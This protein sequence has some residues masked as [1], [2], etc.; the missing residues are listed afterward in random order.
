MILKWAQHL[1]YMIKKW[2]RF[3]GRIIILF[4]LAS[5]LSVIVF[6]F[7]PIPITPLVV[8]RVVEQGIEKNRNIRFKKS[9]VPISKISQYMQLAVVCS[10]DQK[11]LKHFG[12]DIDAIKKASIHNKKNKRTHGASTISQQT[13]KNVFLLPT[14]SYIRKGLEVYFTF[15]IECLWSKERILEVYLNVIEFGDGIYGVQAA[16]TIFFHKDAGKLS[17]G[18]AALLA[19]V[20]PNPLKYKVDQPGKYLLKRKNWIIRQMSHWGY[21][22]D[23]ESAEIEN[24]SEEEPAEE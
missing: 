17:T 14:R 11:F 12:F 18:E 7:L 9:W 8:Q 6:R 19:A 13:A 3:L 1:I 20:L 23:L 10:E 5:I 24:T 2:F 4:V 15:L 21:H 16:S 22:L